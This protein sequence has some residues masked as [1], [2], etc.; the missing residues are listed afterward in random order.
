MRQA[1]IQFYEKSFTKTLII[2][3]IDLVSNKLMNFN[4]TKI[5]L[6]Y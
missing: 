2:V 6:S 1:D 3:N 4:K 5:L